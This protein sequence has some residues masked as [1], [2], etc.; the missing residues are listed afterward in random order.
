MTFYPSALKLIWSGLLPALSLFLKISLYSILISG[1]FLGFNRFGYASSANSENRPS[2]KQEAISYQALSDGIEKID[3]V[4]ADVTTKVDIE[5]QGNKIVLRLGNTK[6][7]PGLI[8]KQHS[9]QRLLRSIYTDN[10]GK[11]GRIRIDIKQDFEYQ[12]YQIGNKLTLTI[13]PVQRLINPKLAVEKYSGKPISVDFQNVEVRSVLHLLSQFMQTNIVASD[14]V[15]GTIMLNLINVPSDQALDIILSSKHLGKRVN[16]NVIL[17][18]PLAELAKQQ[19]NYLNAQQQKI[20][21]LPLRS[22][23]IRLNYAKASEVHALI[24]KASSQYIDNRINSRN[25]IENSGL[26]SSHVNSNPAED[27]EASQLSSK[28]SS[29]LLSSRGVIAVD[30]RTNTLIVKDT[31]DSINNIRMLISQIDIPVQQVMIEARIVSATDN[32]SKELGVKWGILSN[33]VANNDTLLVGGSDQTL[34]DLKQFSRRNTTFKGKPVSYPD[35]AVS[36]PDNL[37]IDLGIANPAGSIAFGILSMSD[38]MIDLELSAMQ[39]EGR[40]EVISTPKILTLDKQTA[41][42]SSGTKIPY[43]SESE[44]GGTTTQFEEALLSLEVTPNIT[45]EGEIS[46]QLNIENGRP[47]PVSSGVIL[48]DTDRLSTHVTVADGQTIV[49][50]GIY[51][52]QIFNNVEKVPFFGDLP[53]LGRLFKKDLRRNDKQELLIFVTPTL[54]QKPQT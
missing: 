7:E 51:R 50:G 47:N 23:Y 12:S 43:Q 41:K 14:E 2:L 29:T 9:K 21:R 19:K 28:G 17:V 37:N 10:K 46:L 20:A 5:R 18:A 34:A 32:F 25:Y 36:R 38:L 6:V 4:L 49:L 35:Y 16:G 3:I 44:G 42:V 26:E 30:T 53:L 13:E 27:D 15:T 8:Y 31:A 54:I 52:N 48:I 40:G 1:L 39:A 22:E 33:G 11:Q 24:L 45:P